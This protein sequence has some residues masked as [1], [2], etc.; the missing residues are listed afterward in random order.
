M[1]RLLKSCTINQAFER[2]LLQE[3]SVIEMSKK[4]IFHWKD[5]LCIR[6]Y[7]DDNICNS[8]H[9]SKNMGRE[10]ENKKSVI[11]CYKCGDRYFPGHP[12]QNKIMIAV[13]EVSKQGD[14]VEQVSD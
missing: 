11:S 4:F 10:I 2:V 8:V 13:E 1:I 3:Q 14:S 9:T 7:E 6:R 5:F 12:C